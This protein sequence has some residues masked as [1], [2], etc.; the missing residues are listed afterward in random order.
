MLFGADLRWW[1]ARNGVPAFAGA[2]LRCSSSRKDQQY[3]GVR[4]IPI[5][6]K[7]DAFIWDGETVGD[8]G[9]SGFMALNWI[10]KRRPPAVILVGFDMRL[11]N[12]VH[13]H[14]AHTGGLSN[15]RASNMP[16]WRNALNRQA[17]ELA[18]RGIAV[19]R[20]S[21]ESTLT[22]YPVLSL[23]DALARFSP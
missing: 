20:E 15:P 7:H 5:K 17:E 14:G 8:G 10:V 13:W 21:A 12:G 4:A 19:Y 9:N 23:R 6:R 2:K 3:R 1:Q 16:R 22:A 11:D 18:K